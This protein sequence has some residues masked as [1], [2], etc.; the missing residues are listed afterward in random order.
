MRDIGV[1]WQS[2]R[3]KSSFDLPDERAPAIEG[4]AHYVAA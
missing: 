3:R 4:G 2:L 1:P